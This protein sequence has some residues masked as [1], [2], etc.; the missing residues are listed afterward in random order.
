MIIII[1]NDNNRDWYQ[2]VIKDERQLARI[3]NTVRYALQVYISSHKGRK[4]T[5]I[6]ARGL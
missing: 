4:I 1:A 2:D 6:S 5:L 3:R